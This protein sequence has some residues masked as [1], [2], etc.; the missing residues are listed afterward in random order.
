[1]NTRWIL[2]HLREAQAELSDTIKRLESTP[3]EDDAEFRVAI[4]HLY[5]HLNTAWNSRHATDA[6][7]VNDEEY[8]GWREFPTDISMP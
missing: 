2:F 5:T 3:P 7:T 8:S 6:Q 4:G 1:M